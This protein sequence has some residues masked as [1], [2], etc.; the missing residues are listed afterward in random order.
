MA[1]ATTCPSCNT[2]F[3]VLPDQLKLR[4]GTVR[5]G[6]CQHVFSG[7]DHLR[8]IP[9]GAR[10][11][12]AGTPIPA[13]VAARIAKDSEPTPVDDSNPGSVGA[14]P[15][16]EPADDYT[17]EGMKT[18]FFMP[19]TVFAATTQIDP[20]EPPATAAAGQPAGPMHIPA[21]I[22]ALR[23]PENIDELLSEKTLQSDALANRQVA[24]PDADA[25]DYFAFGKKS[26]GF[27][28]RRWLL[29]S[30]VLALLVVALVAQLAIIQRDAIA[31]RWPALKAPIA[32]M[33]SPLGLSIAAPQ[34]LSALTIESFELRSSPEPTVFALSALLRNQQSHAVMWPS[35]ELTLTDAQGGLVA[36][37]VFAA[38]EYLPFLGGNANAGVNPKAEVPIKLALET[39]EL[40]PNGYSVTLF[41]P[42]PKQ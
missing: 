5:C 42:A 16:T 9:E 6:V 19:E 22:Q 39:R 21:S 7:L 2:S 31:A 33:V 36:R 17:N 8:Y 10:A 25:I 18:A 1:L 15:L 27:F 35:M 12:A 37:R 11:N 38:A 3:K 29:Y 14:A 26:T 32:Q 30:A 20:G 24:S 13:S 28:D 41:Y 34:E 23:L 4:R 40:V